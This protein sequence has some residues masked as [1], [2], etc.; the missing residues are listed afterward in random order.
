MRL[1]LWTELR[2]RP[3]ILASTLVLIGFILLAVVFPLIPG[4]D[5]T[6]S[7]I[8]ARLEAPSWA[9]GEGGLLGT[10]ELGRD[11]LIRIFYGLK[12]SF[13]V[14]IGAALF[15]A[16]VGTLLGM[17]AGYFGGKTDAIIMRLADV[18][19]S[20]PGLLLVLVIVGALG[21]GI[22]I[23]IFL[24]GFMSWMLF[25]RVI[26][27][28][29]LSF[30][31][32]DLISATHSLGASSLRILAY[33][34]FPNV[35]PALMALVTLR[36]AQLMLAEASLSFLGFGIQPPEISLGAMLAQG[37]QVLSTAWWLSTFAGSF[38]TVGVLS[39]NLVG[40]WLHDQL[41]PLGSAPAAKRKKNPPLGERGQR[42]AATDQGPLISVRDLSVSFGTGTTRTS[43]I[44]SVSFDIARG[45]RVAL[46]GESG[47]GKSLTGLSIMGLIDKVGGETGESSA[48]LLEGEDILMMPSSRLQAVRGQR[49]GMIFQDP[50]ASLNAVQTI[51]RQLTDAYRLH[52]PGL[53][54]RIYRRHAIDLLEQVKLPNPSRIFRAYPHELSGGM[55]QRA[56]IAIALVCDPD[57]LVADEPTTALDVTVQAG[58]LDLMYDLSSE[59]GMA[60]LLITHDLSVV[61]GSVD[62]VIVMYGGRVLETSP[63][64]PLFDRPRHPYTMALMS[65]IPSPLAVSRRLATIPGSPP[66]PA[67][68]PVG[69]LF[70]PRCAYFLP[71]LCDSQRPP[72]KVLSN[73]AEHEQI[74]C[75][76]LRLE[77]I[78][79]VDIEANGLDAAGVKLGE[80][81]GDRNVMLAVDGVSKTFSAGGLTSRAKDVQAVR[82]VSL[83]VYSGE[84]LGIVGES[85]SGKTTLA[86]I[87]GRLIEPTQG[88]VTLLGQDLLRMN[89]RQ[90]RRV[91]RDV[92]MIFQDP[93]SS[94][95]PRMTM[96][97]ILVEPLRIHGLW[98]KEGYDD[99]RLQEILRLVHLPLDAMDRYPR[100]F[101]GGQQQRIAIARALTLNPTLLIC[102]EPVSALD[103][104]VRASIVNLLAELRDQLG[105]TI[106]FVAHD[107]SLVRFLCN[108]IGVMYQ[109]ELVEFDT[110]DQIFTNPTHKH[111]RQLLLSQPEPDP[112]HERQSR[113]ERRRLAGESVRVAAS[114]RRP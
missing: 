44:E 68:R 30:R 82:D 40:S 59:R 94:L 58:V 46:V 81:S 65:S 43:P 3:L 32:T 102:D 8:S 85:G 93:G 69:C 18:Q 11:L 110:T 100:Q 57:L 14:G 60:L 19:L 36:F 45:E 83:A 99:A 108:R 23:M 12:T 29:V 73:K 112:V 114:W 4:I 101:S 64:E 16:T 56:M 88:R 63:T 15:G 76:C 78:G 109:G 66:E 67:Q 35:V 70:A 25:A 37:R 103:V 62:R 92:Q 104:S 1:S 107:L 87:M 34:I 42:G 13:T 9:G 38:L 31:T 91:R 21:R 61:A 79:R 54:K 105:L 48:I 24:L 20:F 84:I 75:A 5:P 95:D 106:V 71:G 28:A 55:R 86:R 113:A 17:V 52:N 2:R 41:D 27:S 72:L 10:D 77:E 89:H 47:S 111:T 90:L 7:K 49:I 39:T 97:R 6:A 96:R 51:G 53:K 22:P 80:V 33:H 98:G 26:R 74:T 50:L